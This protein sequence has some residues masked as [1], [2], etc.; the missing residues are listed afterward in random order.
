[1]AVTSNQNKTSSSD[2]TD[3]IR[4]LE[5]G[6]SIVEIFLEFSVLVASSTITTPEDPVVKTPSSKQDAKKPLTKSPGRKSPSNPSTSGKGRKTGAS[7]KG[8]KHLIVDRRRKRK[9]HHRLPSSEEEEEEGGRVGAID[10]SSSGESGDSDKTLSLPD[11]LGEDDLDLLNA[12]SDPSTASSSS[13][14]DCRDDNGSGEQES[15]SSSETLTLPVSGTKDLSAA[16]SDGTKKGGGSRRQIILAANFSMAPNSNQEAGAAKKRSST[17]KNLPENKSPSSPVVSAPLLG[18]SGR[19]E[20]QF[21]DLVKETDY[22]A[23]VYTVCSLLEHEKT[24]MALRVFV[25]WLT[26]FPIV[27]ATCTTQVKSSV[28]CW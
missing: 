1:M 9:D 23:A 3:I 21:V 12:L 17:P 16:S 7:R 14:E 13:E 26:S 15:S 5:S 6:K 2:K 19:D 24:L 8:K 22:Q 20:G 28:C 11:S 25:Q 4:A 10:G 27:F 18:S